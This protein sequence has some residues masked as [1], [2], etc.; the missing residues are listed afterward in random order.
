MLRSN[1]DQAGKT[2][3]GSTL[4]QEKS[5]RGA[6]HCSSSSLGLLKAPRSCSS[7][8]PGGWQSPG[9]GSASPA[10]DTGV[11]HFPAPGP[12]R[13][14]ILGA[15]RAGAPHTRP[16][17]R[18]PSPTR[19]LTHPRGSAGTPATRAQPGRES[20]QHSQTRLPP[21]TPK[22]ARPR[23]HN[24][25]PNPSQQRGGNEGHGRCV[26]CLAGTE[27]PPLPPAEHLQPPP[28]APSPRPHSQHDPSAPTPGPARP[29]RRRTG[30]G[31]LTPSLTLAPARV[32]P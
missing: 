4:K 25:L 23:A 7:E 24:F 19:P 12:P 15:P 30:C 10:G 2:V 8:P 29:P 5:Q 20:G 31:A 16:G 14:P 28:A 9:K 22:G 26:P 11:L 1:Y 32:S 27:E 13:I 6:R 3:Q 17:T 18:L 21:D